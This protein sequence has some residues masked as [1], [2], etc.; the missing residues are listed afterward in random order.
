[1]LSNIE[2]NDDCI[3]FELYKKKK[4]AT[5]IMFNFGVYDEEEDS[6]LTLEFIKVIFFKSILISISIILISI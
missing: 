2:D 3:S 1:M 5:W 6:F 4:Y